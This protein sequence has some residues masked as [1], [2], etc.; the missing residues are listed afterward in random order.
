MEVVKEFAGGEA[1]IAQPHQMIN[2]SLVVYLL[3]SDILG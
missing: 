3:D 2:S 1:F